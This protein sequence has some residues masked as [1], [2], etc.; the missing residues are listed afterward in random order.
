MWIYDGKRIE[1]V[2]DIP[3]EHKDSYGFIYNIVTS[4]GREYIGRKNLYLRK[5][6]EIGKRELE[7]CPDKRKLNKR[8]SKRGKRK[9]QWIYYEKRLEDS[10]WVDYTGSNDQL[11]KDIKNGIHYTKYILRFVKEEGMMNYQETKAIICTGALEQE[12][13]YNYHAGKF[14]KKNII[15][16]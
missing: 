1:S 7:K 2:E 12:K 11:N 5:D 10:G 9:G 8:K 16:R 14:Y 15:N 3:E 6:R 4:E 13:F